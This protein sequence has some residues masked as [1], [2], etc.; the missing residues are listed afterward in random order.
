[1]IYSLAENLGKFAHE[2]EALSVNE[3]LY[4][5]SHFKIKQE[6]QTLS[7]KNAENKAKR[8][9]GKLP[10]GSS[11]TPKSFPVRPKTISVKGKK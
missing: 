8:E 7:D 2:V 1:M 6:K 10:R 11:H 9:A 3:F 5:I 4:W